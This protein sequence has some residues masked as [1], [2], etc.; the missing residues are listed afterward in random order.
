[1]NTIQQ[2]SL[3]LKMGIDPQADINPDMLRAMWRQGL[4]EKVYPS[5]KHRRRAKM[6]TSREP[7]TVL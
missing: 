6:T 2:I 4:L 5:S 1:M 7:V 3:K